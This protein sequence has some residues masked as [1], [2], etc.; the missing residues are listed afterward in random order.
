[1][2]ATSNA[3]T[4]GTLD[5]HPLIRPEYGHLISGQ[6]VGGDSGS[7]IDMTN[8]ATR[9][10][11]S[12]I[13]AG[14]G[15]DA[16]RAV[17]AAAAAFPAWSA[18]PSVE[19]QEILAEMG[20]RLER[21]AADLA[22]IESIDVGRPVAEPNWWDMPLALTQFQLFSAGARTLEGQTTDE[23]GGIGLSYRKPLGVIAQ[24]IPW[25]SPMIMMSIKVAPALAAG[26]TIVLKPSEIACVSVLE[27]FREM[28][29]LLPPGVVNI[30]TGYGPTVG[31][32]LTTDPRVRMIAFTGSQ[33][34][35]SKL[36]GYA[37]ENIVPQALEL[38][39]KSPIVV[40]ADANLEAAVESAALSTVFMKGENCVAGTR[41]FVHDTVHDEFVERL[42]RVLEGTRRG[43]P[44]DFSVNQ[45]P[46]ASQ[47]QFDKVM[48]YIELGQQEGATMVTGGRPA[49]PE[50]FENGF[51]IE[52]TLFTNV[53]NSMRIAQEE[54]FGPVNTVIR[55]SDENEM[56]RQANDT[57][58]GLASGV[59]TRDLAAAHRISGAIEAGV[60]WVNRYFNFRPNLGG[61]G[62]KKSGF[63]L[64]FGLETLNQYTYPKCVTI[65]LDDSPL[66]VFNS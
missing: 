22:T 35:A 60:C 24:I 65:N 2:T 31:E 59:W 33:V 30:V 56:I 20:R 36:L 49:H 23:P 50:G 52:P 48:G 26:N 27:F 57:K 11:F 66:G 41:L 10:V 40:C 4:E 54:I 42:M 37:S 16:K 43:D 61:G 7:L 12:R 18:R 58:Y 34:T 21:R 64:Q 38:G 63:G 45:G 15:V 17:D 13:Q 51:Y 53:D 6:W 47:A 8:P 25:N 14:N 28:S 32:P 46:Q 29:D 3:R 62:I 1:M 5:S 44:L 55:W 39:G 19:R 9:Q